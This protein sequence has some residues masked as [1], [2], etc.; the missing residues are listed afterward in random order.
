M[1]V[2]E[3]P[4]QM[5]ETKSQGLQIVLHDL[6]ASC[7]HVH[8]VRILRR[9]KEEFVWLTKVQLSLLFG[10]SKLAVTATLF[11]ECSKNEKLHV[12]TWAKAD[13]N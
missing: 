13:I 3:V 2:I 1:T 6:L 9:T 8:S 7:N 10:I 4:Q 5:S 12:K 11:D